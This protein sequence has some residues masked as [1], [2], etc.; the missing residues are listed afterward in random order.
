MTPNDVLVE[1]K[2]QTNIARALGIK[3]SSVAE[4]F[5]DGEVPEGRQY[6]IELATMGRLRASKPPLRA[7][8]EA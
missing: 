5:K 1:F 2:T 4:W 8:I 6:Q 3:P 7:K